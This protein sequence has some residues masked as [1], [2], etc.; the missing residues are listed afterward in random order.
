MS[1]VSMLFST[2]LLS[3][4]FLQPIQAEQ[5]NT[6]I[7]SDRYIKEMLASQG[8]NFDYLWSKIIDDNNEIDQNLLT[9]LLKQVSSILST[10]PTQ[11]SGN[12]SSSDVAENV[13]T[14]LGKTIIKTDD[15]ENN[16]T[17][18]NTVLNSNSVFIVYKP[19]NSPLS[20]FSKCIGS[21]ICSYLT[22]KAIKNR[23]EKDAK[24]TKDHLYLFIKITI[25]AENNRVVL[26]TAPDISQKGFIK[27]Y[28]DEDVAQWLTENLK[29]NDNSSSDQALIDS[30]H[31][32]RPEKEST[33]YFLTR[34]LGF[35]LVTIG[36]VSVMIPDAWVEPINLENLSAILE[37]LG[38]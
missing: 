1:R 33:C 23:L 3:I 30:R 6:I 38:F 29:N 28:T 4:L 12:V 9:E 31:S 15:D 36:I 10:Q 32:L 22:S 14:L 26:E 18:F 2:F 25:D 35:C 5:A 17:H 37:Q 20:N 11:F 27:T 8:L 24:I 13:Q 21:A 16:A 19:T 7:L 34:Y